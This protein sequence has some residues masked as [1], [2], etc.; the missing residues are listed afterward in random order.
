MQQTL[1]RLQE[2]NVK[3]N[4]AKCVFGAR[5]VKFLGFNLSGDGWRIEDDKRKAV[6]NFRRPETLSEVKSFLGLV[7]FTE[8]FI[9]KRA[10]KTTKLRS[11]AKSNIFYWTEQE[12]REFEFLKT[13]ALNAIIRLGYFDHKN[14]TELYVDASPTGL[15]AV[16]IQFNEAGIPRIISCASKSLTHSEQKYP[17]TQKEALA[18]VWSVER[19][20]YYLINKDFNV[21]TDSEANEFI[22]G[23][24][25]RIGRRA[26]T[27]AEAWALR[28][29][30][31]HFNIER[32]PG[33]LNVADALS[34]LICKS[35]IDDAFD[36]NN[37]KH[38]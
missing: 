3:L 14:R 10:N 21:G 1:Q 34:R 31:Y 9:H 26:T 33:Y 22:F 8:R 25:H 32:V 17:Q 38:I 4:S 35:Q 6:E 20:N 30:P 18:I 19:F 7:N 24:S 12:E 28:L 36:E 2:H 5:S 27:R 37:E 15:G 16:L 23:G 13:E 29:L 11:L